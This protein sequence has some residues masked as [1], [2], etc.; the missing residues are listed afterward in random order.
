M[1]QVSKN[2]MI[3]GD[4][5]INPQSK[6]DGRFNIILDEVTKK[7]INDPTSHQPQN[8]FQA[9]ASQRQMRGAN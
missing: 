5:R 7:S 8:I 1:R 6:F 4:K 2:I 9:L 3:A